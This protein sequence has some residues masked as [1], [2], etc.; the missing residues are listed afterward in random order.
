M[1]DRYCLQ[2][3][4]RAGKGGFEM[5]KALLLDDG[6]EGRADV[7]FVESQGGLTYIVSN[8]QVCPSGNQQMPH[9]DVVIVCS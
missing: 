7:L 9:F 2:Q 6:C 4:V 1:S 3:G 8:S 5:I